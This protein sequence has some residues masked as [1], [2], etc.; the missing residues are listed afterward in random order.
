MRSG[1]LKKQL[2][3]AAALQVIF[4]WVLPAQSISSL[5]PSF[6][7]P[8]GQAF[9]LTV[10][11]SGFQS[12]STVS[13]AGTPL[14][15]N[16]FTPSQLTAT[17]P[18][19]LI[20]TAGTANVV[21]TTGS[22][23]TGPFPFTIG[24][25]SGPTLTSVTPSSVAPGG[26]SPITLTV[27]GTGFDSGA[28]V[29]WN[30]SGLITN[31]TSSPTTQLTATV[32]PNSFTTAG[33]VQIT[34]QNPNGGTSNSLTFTIGQ[35][36]NVPTLTSLS[37]VSTTAGGA[38]FT[39]TIN[40]T[41]FTSSSIVNWGATQLQITSFNPSQIMAL[42][43][44]NLIAAVGNASI[45]VSGSNALP[46]SVLATNAPTITSLS[47]SSGAPG[48]PQFLLTVNGTNLQG[49]AI[50]WTDSSGHATLLPTASGTANQ[51]T[52]TVSG[53]LI[54][55]A[56]T[57]TV[58]VISP[59]LGA[60]NG[61]T[62]TIAAASG[63]TLTSLSPSSAVPGSSAITLTVNGTGFSSS[64][65]VN[66]GL[67]QLATLPVNSGT[68]MANIPDTLLLVAG[69]VNVT[70]V[71]GAN[72]SNALTFTIG[73]SNTPVLTSL[74]PSSAQV[75]SGQLTLTVN[76]SN[77]APSANV[78]WNGVPVTTTFN[79]PS[80]LTAT[81]PASDLNTV[82]TP[83]V[84]VVNP[85]GTNATSN[86]LTFTITNAAQPAISTLNPA[87]ATVGSGGANGLTL[88]VNGAGFVPSSIVMWNGSHQLATTYISPNQLAATLTSDLLAAPETAVV[89]VQNPN[90][91]TSLGATFQ[92]SPIISGS[93]TG[94]LAHFAVGSNFTT[95][96]T[97]INTGGTAAQYRIS[98]YDDNGNPILLP[99]STGTTI[100]LA[101]TLSPFGSI[102]VEATNP[103]GPLTQGWGQIS[104]D[105]SIVVQSLFRSTLNN[106]H[107]EAA[108]ESS[109][110]SKA[111][112]LPFDTT[113]F[114]PG[115]PLYTGL[116]IANLDPSN[117]AN[118]TCTARDS[119]GNTI[120]NGITLPAIHALGH[121]AGFQFPNLAGLRG[122]LDCVSN[123]QV[124]VIGLR[125]IGTD[126][127][128]SLPVIK[129]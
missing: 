80:Q 67:N 26:T 36:Q 43:P 126:T 9:T 42:V 103:N 75:G 7:A 15:I 117:T 20:T 91:V 3:L 90:G 33:Q 58:T 47:P 109:T 64:S 11:G 23:T 14:T 51:L 56:G 74:L 44:A 8:G 4:S 70:V 82:G 122:T 92:V 68:L 34:V 55:S 71:D 41:N 52:T 37:P 112:E 45:T 12:N 48:G 2:Y 5:S 27:N 53:N 59:T 88:T 119:L 104:A 100:Q 35:V 63:P 108:V 128:S 62:F 13:F 110:G 97:I 115:T 18:A 86:Q 50:E 31:S 124:A 22:A 30:G 10:N 89:T 78:E 101:G 94:G 46:F 79:S 54:A 73:T 98:F 76:G 38:G 1:V 61:A 123:T 81:I 29:L 60:S 107:Y 114:A 121:W 72:T 125:F 93:T 77:F 24:T 118:V 28:T 113:N 65:K 66:F 25:N 129:K 39:L 21:V 85:N 111:F 120:P 16:S 127:F 96:I 49:S 32:F 40:G 17:V 84:Q 57:A 69:S 95:G 19:S 105:S 102:Y 6:A 83:N 87:S 116:A 106:T 99:F